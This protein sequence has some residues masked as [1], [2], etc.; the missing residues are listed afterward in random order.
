M[1]FRRMHVIFV[2]M[3]NLPSKYHL[4]T[5]IKYIFLFNKKKKVE[6]N[7]AA[8]VVGDILQYNVV[9]FYFLKF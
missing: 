9:F 2:H 7:A 3:S 5:T 1:I 6:I 4:I 8:A